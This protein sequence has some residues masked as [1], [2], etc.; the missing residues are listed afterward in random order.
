VS[1][2]ILGSDESLAA[3]LACPLEAYRTYTTTNPQVAENRRA[4]N[5]AFTSHSTSDI[6]KKLQKLEGFEGKFLSELIE[7]AQ[8]VYN[9]RHMPEDRQAKR[10]PK[11]MVAALQTP[12]SRSPANQKLARNPKAPLEKDQCAYCKQ[13][14]H[15]K[16]ECP[17][18]KRGNQK[19]LQLA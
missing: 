19:V 8:R 18:R 17:K 9:N 7:I 4:I 12:T 6:S 11:V 5:I 15:W 10:L 14:G 2:V 3:F 1:E 16:N 13:K